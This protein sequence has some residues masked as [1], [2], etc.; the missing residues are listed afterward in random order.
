MQNLQLI[1]FIHSLLSSTVTLTPRS[2][3]LYFAVKTK[4]L[5][6]FIC[7]LI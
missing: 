4:N 2:R 6:K 7:L 3:G 1:V 5:N